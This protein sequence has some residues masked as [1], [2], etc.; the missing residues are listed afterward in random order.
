MFLLVGFAGGMPAWLVT[1]SMAMPLIVPATASLFLTMSLDLI[2]VLIRA[3]REVVVRN[4]EGQPT[5][6]DVSAA[7]RIYRIKGFS[8]HVHRDVKAL[9][10]KK[11]LAA[12]Y[13]YEKIQQG[14]EDMVE[15]YKEKL[16]SDVSM[17]ND[18]PKSRMKKL[19]LSL[20]GG[21]RNSED[22]ESINSSI[23]DIT[24]PVD[25]SDDDVESSER[26]FYSELREAHQKAVEL[27]AR[28]P[29]SE[30]S[31]TRDP[32]ELESPNVMRAELPDSQKQQPRFELEGTNKVSELEAADSVP[33]VH[34]LQG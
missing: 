9:V 32:A 34:E 24:S 29:M 8:K 4:S 20:R 14:V 13:K 2:L 31:P 26:D 23:P 3:F 21:N 5:E 17:P 7:A 6:R 15:T 1:G 28:G 16:M 27:E 22:A 25:D 33:K 12:S 10:P 11:N 19:S 18:A 30:L